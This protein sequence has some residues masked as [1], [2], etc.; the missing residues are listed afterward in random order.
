MCTHTP[1]CPDARSVACCAA[2]VQSDH[3]EQGWCRLCNGVILFDDGWYL[4]PEGKI[5]PVPR[6]GA[7]VR[8]VAA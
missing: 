8:E 5:S 4:H 2:H 6:L 1:A 3:S 7:A